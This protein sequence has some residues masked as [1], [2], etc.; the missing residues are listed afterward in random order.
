MAKFSSGCRDFLGGVTERIPLQ[1]DSADYDQHVTEVVHLKWV[2]VFLEWRERE[3][4]KLVTDGR[5]PRPLGN[6]S[7]SWM[8]L[9]VFAPNASLNMS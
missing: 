8:A 7:D 4:N 5:L 3:Y 2:S 1:K 9:S 6:T